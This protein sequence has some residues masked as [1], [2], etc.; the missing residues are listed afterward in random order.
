M[1]LF[2]FIGWPEIFV[3]LLISVLF[4]GAKRIPEIARG[5]GQGIKYVKN[6]TN[7]LKREI[8]DS[9]DSHEGVK[10]TKDALNEGK[11]VLDDLQDS[12]RRST[13]L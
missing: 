2:L 6:A 7:E 8:N 13:R 1:S 11:K 4:F 9:A 10:E 5:L 3:V 12:V